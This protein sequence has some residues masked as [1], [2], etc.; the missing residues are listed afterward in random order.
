MLD[1]RGSWQVEVNLKCFADDEFHKG[2]MGC[3][4]VQLGNGILTPPSP[5]HNKIVG[6][7]FLYICKAI[8]V[9]VCCVNYACVCYCMYIYSPSLIKQHVYRI[10]S[11]YGRFRINA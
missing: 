2:D 11:N 8:H 1:I 5:S 3:S 9:Y 4:L 6:I 7:D 10:A